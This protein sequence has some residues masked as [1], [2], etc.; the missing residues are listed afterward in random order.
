MGSDKPSR[1]S[2][3]LP[4]LPPSVRPDGPL[5]GE[6]AA[7]APY[8]EDPPPLLM[9]PESTYTKPAWEPPGSLPDGD[10][11]KEDDPNQKDVQKNLNHS[12]TSD[13]QGLGNHSPLQDCQSP[14]CGGGGEQGRRHS[15]VFQFSDC[16]V[17]KAKVRQSRGAGKQ[18]YKV[19]RFYHDKGFCQ[20]IAKDH[21]FENVTLGVIVC[22]A[23]WIAVDTDWNTSSTL[24]DAYP[25]FIVADV[26]FFAYFS[27]ELSIRFCA[28]QRK[29]DC[30]KDAWFMFDTFLVMLYA[31]DPFIMACIAAG[32]GGG[33]LDGGSLPRLLRLTRLSR[34]VRMLRALPELMIMIKG[35][36]TA[37]GVVG[38][39]L[40]FLVVVTY[41][42]AIALTQM[43]RG[44]P[45]SED[46]RYLSCVSLAMYSLTIHGT[47][48]DDLADFA[49]AIKDEGD[50]MMLVTATLFVILA[51][52]TIMNM[53]IG[54]LCEVISCVAEE[55]RFG[56]LTD[57]VYEKFQLVMTTLDSDCDGSVSYKEF[58]QLI[59]HPHALQA[60]Q[61][62]K[63][64][65]VMVVDFA[66]E[67]FLDEKGEPKS[68]DLQAFM[69]MV[70]ELRGGQNVSMK[71]LMRMKKKLNSSFGEVGEVAD[72]VELTAQRL[73]EQVKA[74]R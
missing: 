36:I 6:A 10:A 30:T 20:R 14:S 17:I 69:D 29:C 2:A 62:L 32:T 71:D 16:E 43:A 39:T 51:S 64:D 41:V 19:E 48:L 7:G 22:N 46:G 27:M 57:H 60:F 40:G 58:Q 23:I 52:M 74:K 37:A 25:G 5:P 38:Y 72:S 4:P 49:N 73:L 28:F 50:T 70:M 67:W 66:Q 33:G 15:G 45:L 55:E 42:F 56:I 26:L 65:P 11:T 53:L 34:L 61:S 59:D 12:H 3:S 68:L 44:T 54:I 63:V 35:M 9:A 24:L 31:F 18:K 8:S 1:S 21:R 13:T 47:F